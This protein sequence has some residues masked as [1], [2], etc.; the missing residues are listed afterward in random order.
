[1][2]TWI[3]LGLTLISTGLWAE[4]TQSDE[5]FIDVTV[6]VELDGIEHAI[7]QT[8]TSLDTIGVALKDIAGSDNLTDEQKVALGDTLNNLND[9]VKVAQASAAELPS[10]LARSH[11]VLDE[12]S[13]HFFDELQ[14]KVFMTIILFGLVLVGIMV[15]VYLVL[16]RP[17]QR[18]VVEATSHVSQ[19]AQALKITAEAVEQ[20]SARQHELHQALH[21]PSD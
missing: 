1:M 10:A 8:R 12:K 17:L 16:L 15:A 21:T 19:M 14:R 20:S 2:K 6:S 3:S 18:T 13:Q 11:Q 5:A 4:Q 9:L 7:D